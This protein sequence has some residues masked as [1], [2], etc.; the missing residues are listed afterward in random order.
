[1]DN[2]NIQKQI[3]QI[4]QP[5]ELSDAEKLDSLYTLIP[6]DSCDIN[7]LNQATREQLKQL[8]DGTA[9]TQA[10]QQLRR[11]QAFK[12]TAGNDRE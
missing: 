5:K 6:A 8:R 10:M 4:M 3:S 2:P 11:R 12:T 7:N 9:V 1:L